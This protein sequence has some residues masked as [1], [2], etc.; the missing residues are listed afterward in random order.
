[1]D[2]TG[3]S[4][5]SFNLGTVTPVPPLSPQTYANPT[6]HHVHITRHNGSQFPG[7]YRPFVPV[8]P[9]EQ[10]LAR[11]VSAFID[12]HGG[13]D[14][15]VADDGDEIDPETGASIG[16]TVGV[17][18][19]EDSAVL[20]RDATGHWLLMGEPAAPGSRDYLERQRIFWRGRLMDTVDQYHAF[21][22]LVLESGDESAV[23]D[24]ERVASTV[25]LFKLHLRQIE[26]AISQLPEEVAKTERAARIQAMQAERAADEMKRRLRL[27]EAVD[28]VTID[29]GH[30]EPAMVARSRKRADDIA[31]KRAF[32]RETQQQY[33]GD[34]VRGG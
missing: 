24:L 28:A 4:S 25:R 8:L 14:S 11:T 20:G 26:S 16:G 29:D 5:G 31:A 17:L 27:K 1:M 2:D 7:H 15:A 32:N 6:A 13:I 21:K 18:F 30:P 23:A 34:A 12:A 33:R 19:F 22:H 10:A 9:S 3:A